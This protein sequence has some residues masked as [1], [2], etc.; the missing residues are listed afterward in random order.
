ML[1]VGFAAALPVIAAG[2]RSYRGSREFERNAL[3]HQATRDSLEELER[4]LRT[5]SN[6][7]EK[8]R[9]LGFCE[10]VLEMD[11]R[12]FMRLL[13]EVEWYG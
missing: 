8:F 13:C 6:L 9:L 7:N 2:F 1:L 3:R 4:Q 10:L 5:S 12:E 11:C